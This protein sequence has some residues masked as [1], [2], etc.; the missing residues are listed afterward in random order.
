ME[1]KERLRILRKERKETQ[2]Q[3]AEATGMTLRQYQRYEHGTQKPGMDYL[4]ALA[5]HFGVT[6]DYLVGRTDE[7]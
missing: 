3:T 1:L 6:L 5:D 2:A 4:W 7:R